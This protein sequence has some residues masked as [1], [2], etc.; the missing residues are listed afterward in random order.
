MLPNN[1][2]LYFWLV[3]LVSFVFNK[4]ILNTSTVPL[5]AVIVWPEL[6]NVYMIVIPSDFKLRFCKAVI[7]AVSKLISLILS[8]PFVISKV[9][10][11]IRLSLFV[12]LPF[13]KS[14]SF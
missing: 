4:S 5:F 9:F 3:P 1:S 2:N 12:S 11:A 14:S 7:V 8:W 6:L 10:S 13:D